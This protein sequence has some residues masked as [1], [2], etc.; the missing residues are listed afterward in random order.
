MNVSV[1]AYLIFN[2]AIE[3]VALLLKRNIV[4]LANLCVQLI[5]TTS[6]FSEP[7]IYLL[8]IGHCLLCSVTMRI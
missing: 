8:N 6:L 3:S 1:T 7:Y 2:G 4:L 5:N